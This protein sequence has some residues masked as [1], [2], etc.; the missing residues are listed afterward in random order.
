MDPSSFPTRPRPLSSAALIRVALG[1]ALGVGVA[2]TDAPSGPIRPR[3]TPSPGL[4]LATDLDP[5]WPRYIVVLKRTV[6]RA[7][8]VAGEI[9]QRFGGAAF[10]VYEHALKGFAIANVS[11]EAVAMIQRHPLVDQVYPDTRGQLT[12]TRPL[13]GAGTWGLDRID[14]RLGYDNAYKYYFTGSNPGT[15]TVHVYIL[16]TGIRG[17]HQEFAGRLGNHKVCLWASS[18]ASAT[19]DADGHGT[20]VAAIAAGATTGVANQAIIHSV[21][22]NDDV[23]GAWTSDAVCGLNWVAANAIKPAVANMSSVYGGFWPNGGSVSSAMD[24]V[25]AAG[26]TMVKAVWESQ[27]GGT[28]AC[29]HAN[30]LQNTNPIRVSASDVNDNRAAFAD[31]GTCV[32]IFA[33]G[34]NI[35]TANNQHDSH[36]QTTFSGTSAATPFV[37]GVAALILQQKPF[38]TPAFVKRAVLGSA[39]PFNPANLN[40]SPPRLLY[41]LHSY[42]EIFGNGD[43]ESQ[44]YNTSAT[45]YAEVVGSTGVWSYQWELTRNGTPLGVVGTGIS[46]TYTILP[47]ET[48][49]LVL[50]LTATSS[51]PELEQVVTT[52]SVTIVQAPPPCGLPEC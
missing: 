3:T 40:G 22:I 36:Y 28:D 11:P 19:V 37:T 32:D 8:D 50:K 16:D 31:Y 30:E 10:Y 34:A 52:K 24:G 13:S 47:N 38:A 17:T 2:C 27:S 14:A 42:G 5:T 6:P 4:A 25:V 46:Y 9:V 35:W 26:V 44:P 48:S 39:S 51:Q 15:T 21:R 49:N 18:G 41:S 29:A 1:F 43:Y 45:W 7:S 20:A 33:P 23:G 12:G